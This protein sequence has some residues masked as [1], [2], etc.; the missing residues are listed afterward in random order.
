[1]FEEATQ[2]T[3]KLELNIKQHNT[4]KAVFDRLTEFE[5]KMKEKGKTFTFKLHKGNS[6]DTLKK[7]K[8][9]LKK[10]PFAFIDGGHSEDTIKSDYDNLKHIPV[11]VFDDFY[12]KDENGHTVSQEKVGVNKLIRDEME[13]KR[14]H[15]LPSQDK[16]S[17]GGLV[18]L[19]VLLNNADLP[20][21]PIELRRIPIVVHPK[22]CVPKDDIVENI[23]A[24]LNLI[25]S[26]DSVQQYYPHSEAAIKVNGRSTRDNDSS[27]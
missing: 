16:V 4:Y 7:A 14:M 27:F 25:K 6:R 17:G 15:V 11:I 21:I 3:D 23:N 2:E 26:W 12:S 22:D 24:N 19:A 1:M 20:D 8:K 9:E 5:E 10:V 13:G 18:H